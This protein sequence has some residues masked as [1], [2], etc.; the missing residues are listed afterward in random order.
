MRLSAS[1]TCAG[2]A[3]PPGADVVGRVAQGFGALD[4][5]DRAGAVGHVAQA[6]AVVGVDRLRHRLAANRGVHK[7]RHHRRPGGVPGAPDRCDPQVDHLRPRSL[8]HDR[9]EE[10]YGVLRSRN[11]VDRHLPQPR[12]LAVR[13]V[14]HALIH[15]HCAGKGCPRHLPRSRDLQQVEQ[16]ANTAPHERRP[17]TRRAGNRAGE[18]DD[19][20]DRVPVTGSPQ[21]GQIGRICP[22]DRHHVAQVRERAGAGTGRRVRARHGW[23]RSARARTVCAPIKPSPPVTTIMR[24]CR[25]PVSARQGPRPRGFVW[26]HYR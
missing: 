15:P 1:R 3:G 16:C 12:V 19:S 4:E 10:F 18:V 5:G 14:R 7:V 13:C 25:Q 26:C 23:P 8:G 22:R 6:G 9:G 20:A 24:T 21:R 2:L 11:R 17:L